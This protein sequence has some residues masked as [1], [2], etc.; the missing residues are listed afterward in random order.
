[1]CSIRSFAFSA[2]LVMGNAIGAQAAP[3]WNAVGQA[4]GAKGSIAGG[5]YQVGVPRA[6]RRPSRC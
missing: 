2:L 4:L 6:M 3:D 1:M 5:V